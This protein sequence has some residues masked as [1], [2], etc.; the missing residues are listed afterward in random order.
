M[1]KY[2]LSLLGPPLIE[3]NG[4]KANFNRQKSLA[5]LAYLTITG[6]RISRNELAALFWPDSDSPKALGAL[7][8]VLADINGTFSPQIFRSTKEYIE[9]D[10][11]EVDCDVINFRAILKGKASAA[12]FIEASSLWKGGFLKGFEIKGTPV[13]SDWQFLEEQNLQQEYRKLLKRI[14]SVMINEGREERALGFK[15]KLLLLD[16]YDEENHREIMLLHARLGD[17][18]SALQQY[19]ICRKYLEQDLGFPVEEKTALLAEKIRH[20][21]I[22]ERSEEAVSLGSIADNVLPRL[23]VLPVRYEQKMKRDE[24]DFSYIVSEA[25]T[26][27]CLKQKDLEVLSSTS[28]HSY[29]NSDKNL[30]RIAAELKA[31]YIIEGI[32]E[33][34]IDNLRLEAHLVH[35]SKDAVIS[36][37]SSNFFPSGESVTEAAARA[38]RKLLESIG[39]HP[40]QY[41]EKH[42]PGRPWRLH[43][44]SLL[45]EYDPD[46]QKQAIKS[47]DRALKLNRDDASSLAGKSQT[48]L[49]LCHFGIYGADTEKLY[50]EAEELAERAL[51]IDPGQPAALNTIAWVAEDYYWDFSRAEKLYDK[52]IE[53][54][55]SNPRLYVGKFSVLLRKKKLDEA[56]EVLEK[57]NRIAPCCGLATTSR[58]WGYMAARR[59]RRAHV[60]IEE[61]YPFLQSESTS[62][63]FRALI[64]LVLKNYKEAEAIMNGIHDLIIRENKKTLLFA[65]GYAYGA[66]GRKEEAGKIISLMNDGRSKMTGF[67][68]PVAAVYTAMGEFEKAMDHIEEALE[69]RDSG[70]N[71]MIYLPLYDPLYS[72]HRFREQMKRAGFEAWL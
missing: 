13:Y 63:F 8:T 15:R 17:K 9:I 58:F 6:R 30:P 54:D 65:E 52:S 21:D 12:E 25:I 39:L 55:P 68:I 51:K 14:S 50:L 37:E 62:G 35:T 41:K 11:N 1:E 23:A 59:Y 44:Y 29:R 5:I 4:N 38:G 46:L 31:D 61:V 34:R 71:F 48:K 36:S 45:K 53:A 64:Q 57:V 67:S 60:L 7:R 18:G 66:E 40:E 3:I 49:A 43:G 2:S 70:V 47:F 42:D 19:R 28:T 16:P 32:L 27:I 69:N 24:P 72:Y 22:P 20:G 10:R 26:S 33:D 56:L